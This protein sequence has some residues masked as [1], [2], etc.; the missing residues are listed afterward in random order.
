MGKPTHSWGSSLVHQLNIHQQTAMAQN[1]QPPIAGWF[2]YYD[3]KSV[4]HWYH[5]GLSQSHRCRPW[6]F[7][8]EWVVAWPGGLESDFCIRIEQGAGWESGSKLPPDALGGY[9]YIYI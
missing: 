5:N 2:S 3:Q 9:I 7:C 4:G 8:A 1:Y 6:G